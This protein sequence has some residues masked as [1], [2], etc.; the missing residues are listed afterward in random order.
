MIKKILLV[1]F[2]GG[3]GSVCR[4][5]IAEAFTR[6][7]SLLFPIATFIAN[8]LGCLI[9]GFLAGKARLSQKLSLFFVT[10]F[11]GGFTTFS[12]F[13]KESFFLINDHHI[14]LGFGYIIISC[15]LGVSLV[16]IG[17][18]WSRYFSQ[19]NENKLKI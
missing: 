4:Y 16:W 13:S 6:F 7:D 19:K 5:L 18:L 14:Y 12:D 2:G 10:G 15:L 8:M 17:F 1:L 3:I 9:I 11:C